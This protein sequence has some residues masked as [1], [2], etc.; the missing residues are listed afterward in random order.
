LDYRF[1][2]C[3]LAAFDHIRF[4]HELVG[5]LASHLLLYFGIQLH[6]GLVGGRLVWVG[7]HVFGPI[8]DRNYSKHD[9]YFLAYARY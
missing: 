6:F 2:E 9:H 4:L 7:A 3:M 8:V 5:F 1:F